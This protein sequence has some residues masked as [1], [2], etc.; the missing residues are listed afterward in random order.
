MSHIKYFCKG[1]HANI[2]YFRRNKDIQTNKV[3]D[4][5]KKHSPPFVSGRLKK[6]KKMS[7]LYNIRYILHTVYHERIIVCH[8]KISNLHICFWF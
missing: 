8:S 1:W 5:F 7:M 6:E 3:K 2:M 4:N